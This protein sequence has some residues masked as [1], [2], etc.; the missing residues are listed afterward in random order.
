MNRTHGPRVTRARSAAATG[1]HARSFDP[2]RT[3]AQ[4]SSDQYEDQ[5]VNTNDVS[6]AAYSALRRGN[7]SRGKGFDN[8]GS[9]PSKDRQLGTF[10]T[11]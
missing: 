6:K 3:P 4:L 9:L 10:R 1:Q 7:N 5:H 8:L 2:R 11:K